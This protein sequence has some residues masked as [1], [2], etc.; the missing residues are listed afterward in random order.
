MTDKTKLTGRREPQGFMI[1]KSAH[2]ENF[3]NAFINIK[4]DIFFK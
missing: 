3:F 4:Q 2:Q 1:L